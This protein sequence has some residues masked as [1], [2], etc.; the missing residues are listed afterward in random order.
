[1]S[2]RRSDARQVEREQPGGQVDDL[3]LDRGHS[4]LGRIDRGTEAHD[5]NGAFDDLGFIQ[6]GRG[7]SGIG[8]GVNEELNTGAVL[9]LEQCVFPKSSCNARTVTGDEHLHRA[10]AV[11][12]AR[13]GGVEVGV[14]LP[15]S[16]LNAAR[17]RGRVKLGSGEF[18]GEVLH[19]ADR[20][21]FGIRHPNITSRRVA[22]G[23]GDRI[24]RNGEATASA[25]KVGVGR[26]KH[27]TVNVSLAVAGEGHGI[28]GAAGY[29]DGCDGSG[30]AAAGQGNPGVGGV[31]VSRAANDRAESVDGAGKRRSGNTTVA[32]EGHG[33]AIGIDDLGSTEA[34]ET[35][36]E[37]DQFGVKGGIEVS[38]DAQ[39]AASAG[40]RS[41][42]NGV[43][44]SEVMKIPEGV[45]QV[46]AAD[47]IGF[48]E[49]AQFGAGKFEGDRAVFAG[50]NRSGAVDGHW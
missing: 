43:A 6:V 38:Q 35:A 45:D 41:E 49:Q 2:D 15:V 7:A 14:L 12:I 40:R 1:M 16:L 34:V 13:F 47:K 33:K 39:I 32:R 42:L 25:T 21:I 10:G 23:G 4:V 30:A 24:D 29:N 17:Q 22:V 31:C 36:D 26:G 28:D 18:D 5:A 8:D 9:L 11:D 19:V 44:N 50:E 27:I 20:A 3:E 46:A 37:V 48:V